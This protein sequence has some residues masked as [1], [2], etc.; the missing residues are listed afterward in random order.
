M[1]DH[2][3]AQIDL[4]H[5]IAD[6]KPTDSSNPT[7]PKED[8]NITEQKKAIG[9]G[10]DGKG[11]LDLIR[12]TS[13]YRRVAN[14][15]ADTIQFVIN[16]QIDKKMFQQTLYGNTRG[17]NLLQNKKSNLNAWGNTAKSLVGGIITAGALQNPAL[18]GIVVTQQMMKYGQNYIQY[19]QQISQ[20]NMQREK[21]LYEAQFNKDRLV[22]GS[23]NRRR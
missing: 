2:I 22:Y 7:E 20:Y 6:A 3:Q 9:R 5:H 14:T 1:A 18:F 16:Y 19:R 15:T 12:T 11:V 17:A 13:V 8:E 10:E 23:Y 21:T 4:V